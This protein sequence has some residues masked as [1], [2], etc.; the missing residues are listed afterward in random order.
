[1][2]HSEERFPCLEKAREATLEVAKEEAPKAKG[3]EEESQAEMSLGNHAF[4][5]GEDQSYIEI[6]RGAFQPPDETT[7]SSSFVSFL[8][9]DVCGTIVSPWTA[10]TVDGA[11]PNFSS[12]SLTEIGSLDSTWAIPPRCSTWIIMAA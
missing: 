11:M 6:V 10:S 9:I 1:M 12:T 7:T 2:I 3:S 4:E 8:I 5:E